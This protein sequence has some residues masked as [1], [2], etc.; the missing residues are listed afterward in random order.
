M[1]SPDRATWHAQ[2]PEHL[3]NGVRV[4]W[5]APGTD[6]SRAHRLP[7]WVTGPDPFEP[8]QPTFTTAAARHD[9]LATRLAAG[10]RAP[11]CTWGGQPEQDRGAAAIRTADWLN[12][13][14][15]EPDVSIEAMEFTSGS[16]CR[17]WILLHHRERQIRI[18]DLQA[19]DRVAHY[20]L[21]KASRRRSWERGGIPVH[22]NG[23]RM[24]RRYAFTAGF[25][26]APSRLSVWTL[27]GP[28]VW[29][30]WEADV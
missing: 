8:V 18:I 16:R 9:A 27:G 26:P 13:R 6:W 2:A 11:V 12:W 3:P 22:L 20:A 5:R 23:E 25:V 7:A 30:A 29:R 19:E 10:G 15:A 14:L 21:L 24:S 28:G 4:G 1:T 17:G